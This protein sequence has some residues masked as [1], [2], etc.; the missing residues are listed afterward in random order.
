MKYGEVKNA[1]YEV[2]KLYH[3][4]AVIVWESEKGV[5]QKPPY[6]TLKAGNLS[7]ELFP[8]DDGVDN[9][10]H[11]SFLFEINLYTDGEKIK[12]GQGSYQ[13][14]TAIDDLMEF[15]LF[16]DSEPITDKLEGI[17]V[18]PVNPVRDLSDI[19]KSSKFKYRAMCEFTISFY[20]EANGLYQVSPSISNASGGGKEEFGTAEMPAIEQVEI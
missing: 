5:E 19:L 15:I 7:R 2:V 14:N 8:N 11:C 9:G 6:L 18:I 1:L 13:E 20:E 3:P 4:N 16:L 12:V 17:T 10:Y